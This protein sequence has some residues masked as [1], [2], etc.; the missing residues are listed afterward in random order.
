[1]ADDDLKWRILNGSRRFAIQQKYIVRLTDQERLELQELVKKLKGTRQ[2]V[3]RA[4]VLLKADANGP[5]WTDE[6]IADAFSCRAQT[7]EQIRQSLVERGFRQTLDGAKRKNP[8]TAKL[9][10]GEQEARIIAMRSS[11]ARKRT[12]LADTAVCLGKTVGRH[13]NAGGRKIRMVDRCQ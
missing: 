11:P 12:R 1:L 9:L 3:R 13:P 6:R 8:P 5:N 4:Q 10:N 2:K 7:V